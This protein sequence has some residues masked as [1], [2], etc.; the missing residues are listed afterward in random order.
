MR[1]IRVDVPGEPLKLHNEPIPEAPDTGAV[2]KVKSR[3]TAN[4]NFYKRKNGSKF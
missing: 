1:C 2:V 4:F 3:E